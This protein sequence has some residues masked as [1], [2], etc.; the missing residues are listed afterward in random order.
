MVYGVILAGG[1]GERLWP[2]SRTQR[3]KQLLGFGGRTLLEETYLRVSKVAD[4]VW[5]VTSR[6]LERT[7]SSLLPKATI[8][9]EPMSKNTAPA[10]VYTAALALARDPEALLIVVPSDHLINDIASFVACAE[11]ALDLADRGYLVT[12]GIVPTYPAT[13]YGYI[14]RGDLLA[15]YNG[16]RAFHVMRFHEKPEQQ[17]AQKYVESGRFFWNSG[18][19]VWK[20]RLFLDEALTWMPQFSRCLERGVE[21]ETFYQEAPTISV[22]YA[23]MEHTR[24]AAV[25]EARFDWED[26]GSLAALDKVLGS[27]DGSNTVW[28]E[29]I[30]DDCENC[31]LVAED[32]VIAAIGLRDLI[33]IRTADVTLVILRN[34]AQRIRELL[35]KIK[36]NPRLQYLL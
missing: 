11:V 16:I 4:E 27:K 28:G 5:A 10:C 29:I 9:A 8:I 13:G 36:E 18:M 7:V 24:R 26:I 1:K 35:I 12:F 32:G 33:V 22:D 30:Q 21:L 31:I 25:I 2:L 34:Q 14:E 6:E 3:P 19:F 23:V 17:I 15:D 20:A